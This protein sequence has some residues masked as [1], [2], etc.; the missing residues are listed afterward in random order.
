MLTF[1]AWLSTSAFQ[2]GSQKII[3]EAEMMFLYG[4]RQNMTHTGRLMHSQ[5]SRPMLQLHQEHAEHV[6]RLEGRQILK[7]QT[8]L[9]FHPSAVV[10]VFDTQKVKP[11]RDVHE[12]QRLIRKYQEFLLRRE[13][14]DLRR[15]L[16]SRFQRK[17]DLYILLTSFS[18]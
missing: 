1:I 6:A 4:I 8:M 3:L 11:F 9:F 15:K 12:V 7:I 17:Y 13:L 10:E 18:M 16:L 14:L 5:S 2:T